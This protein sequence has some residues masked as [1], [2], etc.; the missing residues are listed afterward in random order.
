MLHEHDIPRGANISLIEHIASYGLGQGLIVIVEGILDAD[1][2]GDMLERLTRS[3]RYALHY[4]FDLTF[5]ETARRHAAR[6]QAAAFT[7]EQMAGWY[8]GWQPLRF[9]EEVRFTADW[10]RDVIV[11]RIHRDILAVADSPKR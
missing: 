11:E 9:V 1:R 5:E 4:G 3:T 10:G 7:L 8:H 2:Y 6:P